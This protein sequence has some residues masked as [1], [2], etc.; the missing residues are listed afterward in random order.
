[1]YDFV[2]DTVNPIRGACP[3]KCKYCYVN[4]LKKRFPVI[5]NKYSGK[6]ELDNRVM[7]K[8]LKTGNLFLINKI[9]NA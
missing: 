1:M 6:I 7:R 9:N 8:K 2:D 5:R 3:H 4:S